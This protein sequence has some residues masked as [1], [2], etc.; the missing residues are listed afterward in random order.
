MIQ[1]A[2]R[3][4]ARYSHVNWALADQTMVSGVN[5]LTGILLAYIQQ[6]PLTT[7]LIDWAEANFED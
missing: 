5:F 3:L 6:G 1:R 4:W 2:V 7:R